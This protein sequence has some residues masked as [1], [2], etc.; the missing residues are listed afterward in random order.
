MSTPLHGTERTDE[1]D[2]NTVLVAVT[3]VGLDAGAAAT[4]ALDAAVADARAGVVATKALALPASVPEPRA[5]K[6]TAANATPTTAAAA[7]AQ[8]RAGRPRGR[9][10]VESYE[11]E[12][13][14]EVAGCA[15]GS[16]AD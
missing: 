8:R 1:T 13:R 2:E 9:G 7:P 6:S 14:A 15:A 12:G 3:G 5:Q 10:K 4:G 16:A 11:G